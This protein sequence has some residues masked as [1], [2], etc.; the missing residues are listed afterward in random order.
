MSVQSHHIIFDLDGTLIDSKPEII[1]TYKEVFKQI[2]PTRPVDFTK[3]NFGATLR[4]VLAEVYANDVDLTERARALFASLYDTSDFK[5]TFLYDGVL[6]TMQALRQLG[7]K[8]YVATN[9]RQPPTK[10]ILELKGFSAVI[11]DFI[12][13]DAPDGK[14]RSKEDMIGELKARFGFRNGFM[15]GD[16]GTD[17]RAGR[18]EKLRTVAVTYGYED[19]NSVLAEKP[20]FVID[21]FGEMLQITK[22][23][24]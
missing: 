12:T 17:I 9:K 1:Y 20:E 6:E 16:S 21:S 7:H 5:E 22:A 18:I 15:V 23:R 24:N 10:R 13:S 2:P 4:T 8:L 3:M 19:I 11:V 14:V